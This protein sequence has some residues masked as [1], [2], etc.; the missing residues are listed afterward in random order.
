MVRGDRFA[1]GQPPRR[2]QAGHSL[3]SDRSMHY[4]ELQLVCKQHPEGE[5][6]ILGAWWVESHHEQF[7]ARMVNERANSAV[8]RQLVD[9]GD[10]SNRIRYKLRCPK[11]RNSP[12]FTAERIDAALKA[13]YVRGAYA[14]I[15]RLRV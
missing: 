8:E 14:T 2:D 9:S 13:I 3:P 10:G 12:V 6:P 15:E 11:C 7:D 4:V 5:E 1:R